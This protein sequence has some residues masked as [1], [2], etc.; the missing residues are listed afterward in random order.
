MS[1][2]LGQADET[3][4]IFDQVVRERDML[5]AER[6]VWANIAQERNDLRV[7]VERL[8]KASRGDPLSTAQLRIKKQAHE[9]E[10]L[11][12][13]E[14]IVREHIGDGELGHYLQEWLSRN[15]QGSQT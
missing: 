4:D 7:E 9:I 15:W 3:I 13:L 14:T 12:A 5:R 1:D 10:R 8:K 6:E 2:K 11:R